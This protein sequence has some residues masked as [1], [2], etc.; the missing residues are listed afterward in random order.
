[1]PM[2]VQGPDSDTW[3]WCTECESYPQTIV[4]REQHDGKE[5]PSSGELDNQC[6]AREKR[7]ETDCQ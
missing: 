6:L 5:W 1:M 4:K 7:G 2:Y 3:H